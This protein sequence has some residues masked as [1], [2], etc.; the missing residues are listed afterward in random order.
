MKLK[1]R[2]ENDVQILTVSELDSTK[3]VDVLRAGITQLYRN[4]KNRIVLELTE[5]KSIPAELLR[6]LGRLKLL[7][8]ELS[9]DIVL[10][11]LDPETKQRIDSFAKP[12]FAI[13]FLTTAQALRFFKELSAAKPLPSAAAPATAAPPV[14]AVMAAPAAPTP[15]SAAP[16]AQPA[17]SSSAATAGPVPAIKDQFKEELRQREMG[18]VGALRKEVE[19]LKSENHSLMELLNKKVL[20][21]REP[22][23]AAAYLAKIQELEKQLA[24][25]LSQPPEKTK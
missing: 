10:S 5:P 8:N 13:S 16:L 18:E 23:D 11:G 3:N 4:G 20:E 2:A 12:P 9:G 21:R 14:A 24:D 25:I 7:A 6:E 19:R 22:P 1:L 17:A 15:P